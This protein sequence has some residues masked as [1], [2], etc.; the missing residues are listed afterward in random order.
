MKY[1]FIEKKLTSLC[2]VQWDR[3]VYDDS[4]FTFYGWIDRVG[5][6]YKDFIILTY[7][8]KSKEW[9]HMSSSIT[10]HQLINSIMD[11]DELDTEVCRR[12]EWA[13]SIKNCIHL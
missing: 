2:F 13:F 8:E 12:V 5:D 11:T 1:P 7:N 10:H 3:F 9:S 6:A 4:E